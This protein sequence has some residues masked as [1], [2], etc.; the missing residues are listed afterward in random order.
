MY[1]DKYVAKQ[2]EKQYMKNLQKYY[3]TL[4]EINVALAK[5]H[6]QI[7]PFIQH[8][9]YERA[10]AYINQYISHTTVW[11]LKFK[12][13]LENPEI[14]LLQIFHLEYIFKQERADQFSEEKAILKEQ[15][16]LFYSLQVFSEE[17]I[18]KRHHA[19]LSFIHNKT[20]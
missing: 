19:M 7:S 16:K 2:M 18:E 9:K 20:M 5:I 11:N 3:V 6:K 13:N 14:A 12:M 17:H 10:T 8:G 4:G 1:T 15:K